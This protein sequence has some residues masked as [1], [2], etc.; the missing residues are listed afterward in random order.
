MTDLEPYPDARG[1]EQAIKAG[2]RRASD[3]D[4][5]LSV[6]Q[7]IQLEYFNR[8]LSR[9]FSEG[10]DSPW[11]L[12]GGTSML[13][14][15]PSTRSTRDIDLH[16]HGVDLDDAVEDLIRL[17]GIDLGDHFRFEFASRES[18]RGRTSHGQQGCR[19]KFRILIGVSPRGMLHVDLVNHA[20]PTGDVV[21]AAPALSLDLPRLKNHAY[22]L[23]P[24][25]DQI[26]DKVCATMET[27]NG[28]SSTREKDLVDL[29]V[30]ATTQVIEGSDLRVAIA[31]ESR[32]RAMNT[33]TRFVVPSGWGTAYATQARTVPYCAGYRTVRDAADL[34]ARLIDPVMSHE[35]DGKTWS[36][37]SLTWE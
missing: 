27:Y 8:F 13:A 2:A 37:R 9:V 12:K 14:R 4:P 24:V 22:R 21:T 15:V 5:S 10:E 34:V 31:T 35:A 6:D 25:V 33:I 11:M 17:A 19:V 32:S 29:V 26:A 3:A 30:L 1:V 18:I 23:Y 36:Y 20:V 28:R 16:R 7:R